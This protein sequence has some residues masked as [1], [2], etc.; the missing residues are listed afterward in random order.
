MYVCVCKYVNKGIP[1]FTGLCFT[2][3]H[4]YCIFYKL[5]FC[6]HPML[7]KSTGTIF[8]MAFAHFVSLCHILVIL[9]IFQTFSLIS[10]LLW[11]L[12]NWTWVHSPAL[13]QSQS[14]DAGLWWRKVQCLLQGTKQWERAAHTEKIQTPWW[15]SGK[16]FQRQ[17]LGWGLKLMEFLL[18]GWWCFRNLNHQPSGSSQSGVYVFVVGMYSPSSTWVS[19]LVSAEQLKDMHQI[20]MYIPW[21]ELGLCFIAELFAFPLFLHSLTSLM[22]NPLSL[23]FGTQGRPRRLKPFSTNKKWGTGRSFCTWESPAGSCSVSNPPFSLILP[24]SEGNR[25]GTRK[26]I[27]F[28]IE[29]LIINLAGKLSFRGTPFHGDWWFVIGDLWRYSCNC[30]G[31]HKPQPYKKSNLIDKCCVYSDCST[32]WLFP[33]S[34][35]SSGLPIA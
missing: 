9:A 16:G 7:S 30:F 29:R 14:T 27:K 19:V 24:N 3:L 15:L 32:N 17:Y 6:G 33:V 25:G 4:R 23:L 8:P 28:W 12:V 26:G 1:Y 18:T 21:G 31:S 34:P 10:Y 11:L 35:H 13:Q 2:A 5:K 22:S 20:V